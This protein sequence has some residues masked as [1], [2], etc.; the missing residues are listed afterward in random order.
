MQLDMV[1]LLLAIPPMQ[2]AIILLHQANIAIVKV[3]EQKQLMMLLM[4]KDGTHKLLEIHRMLKD[5]EQ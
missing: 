1:I 5:T 2:R 3:T 4:Q